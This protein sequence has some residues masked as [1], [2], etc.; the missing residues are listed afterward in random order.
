MV[1]WLSCE[2]QLYF[3]SNFNWNFGFLGYGRP[4][5]KGDKGDAG[6]V[7]SSGRIPKLNLCS[8]SLDTTLTCIEQKAGMCN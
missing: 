2:A 1:W 7:S 6:F 5:P 4:G 3:R 8:L